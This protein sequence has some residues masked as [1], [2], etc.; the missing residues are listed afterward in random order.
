MKKVRK[1]IYFLSKKIGDRFG[2]DLPYYI[3]NGFWVLL[4][5]FVLIISNLL[6]SIIMARYLSKE[7]YGQYQFVLSVLAIVSIF[8]IPGLNTSVMRSV[9]KGMDGSYIH[10]VKH[11]FRW[12]FI[13]IP[14]LWTIAIVF[15]LRGDITISIALFIS[16]LFFPILYTFNLWQFF[17]NGKSYFG[18]AAT[19]SII[20]AFFKTA[21]LLV[22]A[23]YFSNNVYYILLGYL[24]GTSGFHLFWYLKR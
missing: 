23:I 4:N 3:E 13:G 11:S 24:G 5:Q 16:S 21:L 14:V 9:A 2:F 12:S 1:R 6:L 20:Q 10:A 7:C 17:Y 19:N 22:L 8:S 18:L 15:N